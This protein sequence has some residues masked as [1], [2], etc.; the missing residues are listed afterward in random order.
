MTESELIEMGDRF[1][2]FVEFIARDIQNGTELRF[3]MDVALTEKW[4]DV[5]DGWRHRC[6]SCIHRDKEWHEL[7]CDDCT[8][9]GETNH[10][11]MDMSLYMNQPCDMED[12]DKNE[13]GKCKWEGDDDKVV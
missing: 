6:K 2:D 9:G 4:K 5:L 1:G 13:D 10:Y 8:M 3:D 7:P 11:E 12:C